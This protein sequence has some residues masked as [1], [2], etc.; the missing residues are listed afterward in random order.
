MT[1]YRSTKE[2]EAMQWEQARAE[3][4]P[5]LSAAEIVAWINDNGGEAIYVPDSKTE[6]YHSIGPLIAVRT[7]NGWQYAHPGY[8][9][10]KGYLHFCPHPEYG[11]PDHECVGVLSFHSHDPVAFEKDWTPNETDNNL[12]VTRTG[13]A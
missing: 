11:Q 3:L 7:I 2:V 1:R 5:E 4:Q 12:D 10:G 13:A 8:Y 9:I 6:G